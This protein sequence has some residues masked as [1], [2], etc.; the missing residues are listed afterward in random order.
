MVNEYRQFR[1]PLDA[2]QKLIAKRNKIE[3]KLF[4]ISR[5]KVRVPLTRLMGIVADKTVF[6]SDDELVQTFMRKR[7]GGP[8]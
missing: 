7:G 8:R 2:Y 3:D 5:K 6:F 4:S 1:M